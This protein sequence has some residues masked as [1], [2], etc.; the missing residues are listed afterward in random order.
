MLEDYRDQECQIYITAYLDIQFGY[1]CFQVGD[2]VRIS[3]V[4]E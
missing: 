1:A 3:E 2:L 4:A